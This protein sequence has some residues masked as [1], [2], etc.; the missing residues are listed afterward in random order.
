[1]I[2]KKLNKNVLIEKLCFLCFYKQAF[3]KFH[4]LPPPPSRICP[5]LCASS[6]S[7][8]F[9]HNSKGF[10]F[11]SGKC[12]Y[13]WSSFILTF[14]DILQLPGTVNIEITNYKFDFFLGSFSVYIL[15]CKLKEETKMLKTICFISLLVCLTIGFETKNVMYFV[16]STN[17]T[18]ID[19]VKVI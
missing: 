9:H 10:I 5:L 1:M 13:L 8:K 16:S 14:L 15:T 19:S 3:K 4:Y 12:L 11:Y 7:D 2:E 6:I 17:L 18:W